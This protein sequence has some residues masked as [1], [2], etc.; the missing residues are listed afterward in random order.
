M[1]F[2]QS[3][4]FLLSF[5]LSINPLHAQYFG[6]RGCS[7]SELL[8]NI[9][10]TRTETE[11]GSVC[12]SKDPQKRGFLSVNSNPIIF[13]PD[14]L[15]NL[16]GP[17]TYEYCMSDRTK[18]NVWGLWRGCVAMS[19]FKAKG[20]NSFAFTVCA[21]N[22]RGLCASDAYVEKSYEVNIQKEDGNFL[23]L[24]NFSIMGVGDDV[25]FECI[26]GQASGPGCAESIGS[27]TLLPNT[28]E[29]IRLLLSASEQLKRDALAKTSAADLRIEKAE[30]VLK[31][32]KGRLFDQ[33]TEQDLADFAEALAILRT[34]RASATQLRAEVERQL[35]TIRTSVDETQSK[36]KIELASLGIDIDDSNTYKDLVDFEI[37]TTPLPSIPS[38]DPIDPNDNV[39]KLLADKSLEAMNRSLESNNRTEFLQVTLSWSEK[40]KALLELY[41]PRLVASESERAEYE[42]QTRRV[43]NFLYGADGKQGVLDR[44]GWFTDSL[45]PVDFQQLIDSMLARD[46]NDP[47]AVWLKQTMRPLPGKQGT[48]DGKTYSLI[49]LSYSLVTYFNEFRKI[50]EEAIAEGYRPPP[51]APPAIGQPNEFAGYSW[52]TL[53]KEYFANQKAIEEIKKAGVMGIDLYVSTSLASPL[54]SF[55][56]IISGN[57]TC[58]FDG[59]KDLT[60]WDYLFSSV[61]SLAVLGP[62]KAAMSILKGL[63][64]IGGKIFSVS[65]KIAEVLES[66]QAKALE[67]GLKAT[68]DTSDFV[69]LLGKVGVKSPGQLVEFVK[70][71]HASKSVKSFLRMARNADSI[72]AIE[73]KCLKLSDPVQKFYVDRMTQPYMAE[74][75]EK[76]TIIR[77]YGEYSVGEVPKINGKNPSGASKL[78]GFWSTKLYLNEESF[79]VGGV[80]FPEWNGAK[81]VVQIRIKPAQGKP[82]VKIAI[83]KGKGQVLLPN[84]TFTGAS[85]VLDD[86]DDYQVALVADP[87]W[88]A[89]SPENTHDK[90]LPYLEQQGVI[91]VLEDAPTGWK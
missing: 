13:N 79:R 23:D 73:A 83:G 9:V 70:Y 52:E 11:Q 50:Y 89:A 24:F 77:Y 6:G 42:L 14:Q 54:V 53:T 67:L 85:K 19:A 3:V 65:S 51:A 71:L 88:L 40:N 59:E 78:G 32:I 91:E 30:K 21:L 25:D 39:Y 86:S 48:I 7:Q 84:Q 76:I 28:M 12:P 87:D 18:N 82:K 41:R 58:R 1:K 15:H 8:V 20:Q 43:E 36:A 47:F 45:V 33:L 69:F 2:M 37:S 72:A 35:E 66:V 62:L 57:S 80:V 46:A 60:G 17:S 61:D 75:K 63:P 26:Q 64:S 44:N 81:R 38:A 74:V 4:F 34:E 29:A 49:L 56:R 31:D 90:W 5:F 22:S 55:C 27:D 10:V 16:Y 68:Q